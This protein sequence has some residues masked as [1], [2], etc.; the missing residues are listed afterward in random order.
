MSKNFLYIL[1]GA[2]NF[3]AGGKNQFNLVKQ[4]PWSIDKTGNLF[5]LISR[6]V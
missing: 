3:V 2:G 6:S 1:N 5:Q 4:Q